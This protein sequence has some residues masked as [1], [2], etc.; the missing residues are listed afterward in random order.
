MSPAVPAEPGPRCVN[1]ACQRVRQ[2]TRWQKIEGARGLCRAGHSRWRKAGYPG[3]PETG[4]P[5]P[6]PKSVGAAAANAAMAA[7][8][9]EV[10]EDFAFLIDTGS[11]V[12]EAAARLGI[13]LMT[14]ERYEAARRAAGGP[15]WPYSAPWWPL[16]AIRAEVREAAEREAVA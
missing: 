12:E 14:A 7:K 1:P 8:R 11:T 6:K 5:D 13:S 9:A 2:P 4:V 3:T 16:T 15:P 10:M